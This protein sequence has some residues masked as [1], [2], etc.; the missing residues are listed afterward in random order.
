MT[1]PG[2]PD[3]IIIDLDP[4]E[5]E[6]SGKGLER[7]QKTAM[8]AQ[9]YCDAKN[10]VTFVKTS[11]KTGMHFLVPC[12]GFEF[13]QAR[14]FAEQICE[15]IHE[16]VL[17]VST[18][19][20]SVSQRAGKVFVDP[21]QNDYADTIAAPYSLRPYHLPTVSTPIEKR[22]LKSID[23]HEFMMDNIF[24]RLNKKGDLFE[25]INDSKMILHNVKALKKM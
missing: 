11:G 22:E 4:S 10:L 18:T 21:S 8:A 1:G 16:L 25:K 15:G 17:D 24:Q 3:Y 12:R 6:R 14:L 7:L 2:T 19:N 20:V 9:E 23:P 13:T 5:E